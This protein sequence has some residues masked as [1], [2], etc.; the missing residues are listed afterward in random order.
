VVDIHCHIIHGVDD[1]PSTL[2]ESIKMVYKAVELGIKIIVATP[3]YRYNKTDFFKKVDE[4]LNELRSKV[5]DLDIKIFRG[6]E[7][8]I[9]PS[10]T[11]IVKES[12]ELLIENSKSL[13][14]E[15][16]Y[17][18]I[19]FF[20]KETLYNLQLQGIVP[21]IA[22]AE[23][24]L[25]LQQN[26]IALE[27]ILSENIPVQVDAGSFTGFNGKN[28]KKL[29]MFL[30]DNNLIDYIASDAH[31]AEDYDEFY[32]KAY[33]IVARSKGQHAAN[34]LFGLNPGSIWD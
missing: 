27:R 3:H 16:P 8:R 6:T 7:V 19:P 13:L 25:A 14:V 5:S 33:S 24:N 31:C 23:R 28:S 22:H 2:E 4:N 32:S 9:D 34:M 20:T 30:L 1:G 17:D 26:R 29:A 15:F 10:L 12:D 21:I 11:E 18:R